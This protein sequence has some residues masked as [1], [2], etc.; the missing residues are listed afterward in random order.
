MIPSIEAAESGARLR[1]SQLPPLPDKAGLGAPFAGVSNGQLLVAGG[2]NFPAAPL[3]EGGKKVWHDTVYS[4][5]SPD[6]KWNL[7]GKLPRPLAYGISLTTSQGVLCLGGCDAGCH[8]AAVFLLTLVNG[9]LQAEPIAPLPK[10]LAY[11]CGALVGH[12][13]YIAGGLETPNSTYSMRTFWA[14]DL[15]AKLPHWRE[16]EPWPGPARMLSVAAALDGSFYL[17]SGC[18]LTPLPDGKP[19]RTYQTDAYRFK[20]SE[21]WTRIADLPKPVVA[22]PSPAAALGNSSIIVLGADDGSNAGFQPI[23]KHPGFPRSIF[24]YHVRTDSWHQ[25]NNAPMSRATVPVVEWTG[26]FVVPSGEMGPGV[27]S[28]E[29]W[30]FASDPV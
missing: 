13:A 21:G 16:L 23:Q 25:A 11:A 28:P 12:T 27:R 17:I 24:T 29:V 15:A 4:L 8:Y 7:A 20:P 2:T 9:K 3:W 5:A 19:T 22:A 1:W 30:C 14:L 26:R 18:E 6:S 10:P